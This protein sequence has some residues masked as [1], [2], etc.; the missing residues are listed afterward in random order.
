[1][2]R[3]IRFRSRAL[4]LSREPENPINPIAGAVLLQWLQGQPELAGLSDPSPEDWGWYSHVD[5]SGRSYMVGACIYP[6]ASGEHEYLI[7]F[8]KQ[9]TL[10]E[11]LTGRAKIGAHDP[12]VA[13]V[14][15]AVQRLGE[16]GSVAVEHGP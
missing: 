8:Q 13:R 11:Q 1:M 2:N 10:L 9:R 16:E 5:V 15:S 14:L 6:D 3:I 12:V 7:Q 4:D